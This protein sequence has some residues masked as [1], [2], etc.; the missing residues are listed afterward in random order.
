MEMKKP[1]RL[2]EDQAIA[3]VSPLWDIAALTPHWPIRLETVVALATAADFVV[4][5]EYIGDLVA[6]GVLEAPPNVSG[7]DQW[8]PLHFCA[9]VGLLERDE[10]WKPFPSRHDSKKTDVR[11]SAEVRFAA[12]KVD[13]VHD[14]LADWSPGEILRLIV[15]C[16]DRDSRR[17]LA[18]GLL[19]KMAAGSALLQQRI[20]D[21]DPID[22]DEFGLGLNS[23]KAPRGE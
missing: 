2:T 13:E 3:I 17:N 9:L 18:D 6:K 16:D 1:E 15:N 8:S 5:G 10:R 7:Q 11:L 14:E 22:A 19:A 23:W 4:D 21:A 20:D 12:G